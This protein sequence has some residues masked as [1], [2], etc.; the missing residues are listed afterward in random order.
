[1]IIFESLI[2]LSG[3]LIFT[4]LQRSIFLKDRCAP[5]LFYAI[6]ILV[7]QI[8]KPDWITKYILSFR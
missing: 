2:I 5:V 4:S 1:M 3:D 8:G 6:L 7:N